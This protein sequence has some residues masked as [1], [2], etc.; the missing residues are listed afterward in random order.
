MMDG[1]TVLVVAMIVMMAVMMGGML[2]G[3][4]WALLRRRNRGRGGGASCNGPSPHQLTAFPRGVTTSQSPPNSSTPWHRMRPG[5]SS[6][7]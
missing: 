3:G 4:A 2:G 6:L 1:S 7:K 5:A